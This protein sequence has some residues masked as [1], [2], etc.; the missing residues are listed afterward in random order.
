FLPPFKGRIPTQS[1]SGNG[2]MGKWLVIFETEN[3][4]LSSGHLGLPFEPSIFG[5]R[6]LASTARTCEVRTRG[7]Y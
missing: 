6:L 2:R 3:L 7:S 1:L 4:N 5:R